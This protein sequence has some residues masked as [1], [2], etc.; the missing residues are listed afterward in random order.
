MEQRPGA[1][2]HGRSNAHPQ[3]RI[4]FDDLQGERS[5]CGGRADRQS[6]LA[7]VLFADEL[8]RRLP[9]GWVTA[10][11]LHPGLTRTSFGAE[12]RRGP[13]TAGPCCGRSC[14]PGQGAATSVSLASAPELAPVTGC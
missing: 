7:N 1:G 8:A 12:T 13:A 5:A 2:G 9:G 11:V 6:K 10:N 14:S 3:G 4:D